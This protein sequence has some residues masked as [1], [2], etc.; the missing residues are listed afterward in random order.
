MVQH[1]IVYTTKA[2]PKRPF[3]AHDRNSVRRAWRFD[4]HTTQAVRCLIH[5]KW[6]PAPHINNGKPTGVTGRRE[7]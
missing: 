5:H 2:K 7:G 4:F 1:L 3:E 6:R